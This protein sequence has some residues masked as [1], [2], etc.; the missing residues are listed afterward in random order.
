MVETERL[1]LIPLTAR[2]LRMLVENKAAL[3]KD[4]SCVYKGEPM[5]GTFL[6]IVK[7]QA[8]ITENDP[9]NYPWLSFWLLLRK[10][11]R[12]IVGSADFKNIPHGGGEVEI[13]Y[14]LGK[15]FEHNGYMTEAVQAMCGWAFRQPGVSSVIAETY[16][17]NLA[18]QRVLRRCGF[19]IQKQGESFWWKLQP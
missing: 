1:E 16:P 3:E 18:S 13:G 14:G 12:F 15:A 8:E 6:Q 4:L 19:E 2:Q 11:D 9:G 17:D 5:E 10:S 7:K